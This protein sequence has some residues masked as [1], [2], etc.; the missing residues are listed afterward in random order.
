MKPKLTESD[1]EKA[2]ILLHH[3]SNV[4]T[5]EPIQPITVLSEV[6]INTYFREDYCNERGDSKEAGQNKDLQISQ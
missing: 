6:V 5:E 2:E 3:F 4:F 1:K